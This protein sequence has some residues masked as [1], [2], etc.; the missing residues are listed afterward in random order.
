MLGAI[1]DDFTGGTDVAV[2]FRR[3]GLRTV[4]YFKLPMADV[5]PPS[6]DAIVV[7]L[8][9]RMIPASDAVAHSL[10]ALTWLRN[11]G[12]EQIYFKYCS[13]FDSSPRG[14]IGPVLDALADRLAV[15]SVI[16]TPSSPEHL[17]S[18]YQGY[19][20]VDNYLLAESHMR[21]HSVTPMT[22]SS[23][24]RLLTAQTDAIVGVI[25]HAIVRQG[26]QRI[27]TAVL[28]AERRG[29]KYLFVDALDDGDLRAIGQAA[30]HSPLVA[31]A[32]GLAGGLAAAIAA[33]RTSLV[34]DIVKHSDVEMATLGSVAVLAGSCSTRTL[35]QIAV[36][37]KCG[38][39]LFRLEVDG[40]RDP[41]A[42]AREALAWFDR[43]P[44][45]RA[46]LI[47][48]SL[49]PVALH[50]VQETFGVAR[51]AQVLEEAAGRI[52]LGL[53]E[54]GVT[55]IIVAGGETAGAIVT[56]LDVG[57]GIIGPEAARGVPWIFAT[58]A[59]KH[60]IALLLKSGNFGDAHFLERVSTQ[61]PFTPSADV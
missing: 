7:A 58:T 36:L 20:F 19:L 23:L 53:V 6:V 9:T 24:P 4:I 34:D 10:E 61:R 32:A 5:V 56:A 28:D 49:E 60:D 44:L 29:Q 2:A 21:H 59:S 51:S 33:S 48:S 25:H 41:T 8:K 57:G 18:Q 50:R 3:Q 27:E 47:Y 37:R 16:Q 14:N 46:P 40:V 13:T 1:A 43:Q 26:A 30:M 35:E 11:C 52:A 38:H 15:R 31:G 55:R 42:L 17:R 54:R 45:L 39:P 22:D 12:A